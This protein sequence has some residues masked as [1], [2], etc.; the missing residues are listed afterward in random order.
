M[1]QLTTDDG[2]DDGA[3]FLVVHVRIN[4]LS[5]GGAY[6]YRERKSKDQK[7]REKI[8]CATVFVL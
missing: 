8:E 2:D 6:I 1:L 4:H 3:G 5:L 7:W